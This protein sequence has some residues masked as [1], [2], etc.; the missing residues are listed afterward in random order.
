MKPYSLSTL[1][2]QIYN[3]NISCEVKVKGL[4][5]D[6]RTV[7]PGDCF[8]ALQGENYKGLVFAED[9]IKKGAVAVITSGD[10]FAEKMLYGAPVITIPSLQ[11]KLSLLAA[12]F[13]DF[14]SNKL[15]TIGVT[16]T[17]GKTSIAFLLA[18]ILTNLCEK[19]AMMGTIGCGGTK[20]LDATAMTTE[21][22][23][24]L[25]KKMHELLGKGFAGVAMEVSSHGIK[26][27]RIAHANFNYLIFTNITPDHLDYHG[28]FADYCKT[29]LSL[30]DRKNVTAAIVNWND[31]EGRKICDIAKSNNYDCVIYG[32]NDYKSMELTKLKY[33]FAENISITLTGFKFTLISSWGRAEIRG[34]YLGMTNV[35]NVLAVITYL[36][37]TGV[38]IGVVSQVV[39]DLPTIPGRMQMYSMPSGAKVIVDY[40]HTPDSLEHL[41]AFLNL[42]CQGELTCIFGCGG[43]RD[44]GRRYGMGRIADLYASHIVL[45]TDNPRDEDV[46]DINADIMAKM[47]NKGKVKF[48]ENRSEAIR[49]TIAVANKDD[50]IVIIGKGHETYQEQNGKVYYHSDRDVVEEM[51]KESI[52]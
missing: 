33:V 43:N 2:N 50:V 3:I 5:S 22:A 38:D 49:K 10:V 31:T 40:A 47:L 48:I 28:S 46:K 8:V 19:T 34:G 39:R 9:A 12:T 17:N 25:H 26:Q 23:V 4:C 21:P 16:G 24:S 35:D 52:I 42:Q 20:E 45:T 36:L 11:N 32:T 18:E 37:T 15:N 6:S 1:I 27:G 44:K 13:Y 29:K 30:F 41:L 51:S 7:S 14:P